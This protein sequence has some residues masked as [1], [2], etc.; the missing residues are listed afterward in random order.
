[1][2]KTLAIAADGYTYAQLIHSQEVQHA[3]TVEQCRADQRLWLSK[4]EQPNGAGVANVSYNELDDWVSEMIDCH[5]V[6]P[7]FDILYFNTA[8]EA[9]ATMLSR[10]ENFLKRHNSY[11]QFIAEDKQGKR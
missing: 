9:S 7:A 6:D 5:H 4:L 1:L 11:G 10:V 8:G 2:K 3:P